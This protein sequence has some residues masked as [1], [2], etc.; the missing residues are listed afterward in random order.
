MFFVLSGSFQ[1]L[2]PKAFLYSQQQKLVAAAVVL[3]IEYF[4]IFKFG[5]IPSLSK[6]RLKKKNL[7]ENSERQ[8]LEQYIVCWKYCWNMDLFLYCRST[9]HKTFKTKMSFNLNILFSTHYF[10][11]TFLSLKKNE[12]IQN[13]PDFVNILNSDAMWFPYFSGLISVLVFI[14]DIKMD[15][16]VISTKYILQIYYND[17]KDFYILQPVSMW[18]H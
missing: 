3:R 14:Q 5:F 12:I 7:K 11:N 6:A 10:Q 9:T 8:F 18:S 2:L 15:M 13:Q 1:H 4:E 17:K 16:W